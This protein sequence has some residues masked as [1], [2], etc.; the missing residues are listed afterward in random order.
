MLALRPACKVSNASLQ[1]WKSP[2]LGDP[3]MGSRQEPELLT[4]HQLLQLTPAHRICIL[5]GK[6]TTTHHAQ[7]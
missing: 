2:V 7:V 5:G 1:I 4:H 6:K 3:F